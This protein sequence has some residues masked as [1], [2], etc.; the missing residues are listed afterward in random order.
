M[1]DHLESWN[2][3]KILLIEDEALVRDSLSQALGFEG[4]EVYEAAN[5]C[6]GARLARQIVPDLILSDL[7]LPGMDGVEVLKQIRSSASTAGIPFIILTAEEARFDQRACME[8]G[9][10]D[11]LTKPLRQSQVF[12][13]IRACLKKYRTIHKQSEDLVSSLR[14]S[15]SYTMPHEFRTPLNGI[16]GLVDLML[17]TPETMSPDEMREM[18]GMVQ[19]CAH[20]LDR[21]IQN[22]L[23]YAQ[24]EMLLTDPARIKG[25]R[26]CE[27]LSAHAAT[28]TIRKSAMAMAAAEERSEDLVLELEPAQ[29]HIAPDHLHKAVEE[30]TLNALRYSPK[31]SPVCVSFARTGGLVVL[32]VQDQ[33]AGMKPEDI[34]KIGAH[35]QFGRDI[36]E[37]QGGGLGLAIVQKIAA[38]ADGRLEIQSQPG[39]P[40]S[41]LLMLHSS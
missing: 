26:N 35:I 20:R 19:D 15:I 34:R 29:V 37:Q 4:F 41:V 8:L 13:A 28:D 31:E 22:F 24:L 21:L 27:A 6:D 9:A 10:D 12:R 25:M 5:G 7:S 18:L 17:T 23:T 40:T 32:K 30:L 38:I 39:G 16:L 11:Y 1:R 3:T 2:G 36:R 14:Q 33:G